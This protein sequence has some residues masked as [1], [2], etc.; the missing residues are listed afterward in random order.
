MGKNQET[1]KIS[2]FTI[3]RNAIKYNYP[4]VESISSILHI[5][6]EFIINVGN[7]EDNTLELIRSIS[8]KKI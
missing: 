2:A 8:S 3:V 7:S 1:V 5:V 4:I 6:D